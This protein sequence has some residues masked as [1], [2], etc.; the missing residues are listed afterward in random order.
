MFK[1]GGGT[2]CHGL[3]R[4]GDVRSQAGLDEQGDLFQPDS[5]ITHLQGSVF[6]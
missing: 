5:V 2:E 1:T 6:H 4:H 3:A